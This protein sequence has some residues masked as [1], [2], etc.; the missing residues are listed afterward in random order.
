PRGVED[1][2]WKVKRVHVSSPAYGVGSGVAT[3]RYGAGSLKP[4]AQQAGP[5]RLATRQ[6][7][8]QSPQ[9]VVAPPRFEPPTPVA[10]RHS[11]QAAAP[12][13]HSRCLQKLSLHRRVVY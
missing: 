12:L 6:D 7:A 3:S 11:E 9:R 5:L 8:A 1:Q 13:Q 10:A 4:P 2:V